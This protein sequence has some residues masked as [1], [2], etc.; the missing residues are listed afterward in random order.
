[1]SIIIASQASALAATAAVSGLDTVY[2]NITT[3]ATLGNHV[4]V[5]NRALTPTE[6]SRLESQGYTLTV[7]TDSAVRIEWPV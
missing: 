6:S 1:M 3:E 4:L 5:L 7:L 2:T